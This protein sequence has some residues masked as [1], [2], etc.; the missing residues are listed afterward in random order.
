MTCIGTFSKTCVY[1]ADR[2]FLITHRLF[3]EDS[4]PSTVFDSLDGYRDRFLQESRDQHPM[5]HDL[6]C[7]EID[8][9][10]VP[11]SV[12]SD[13]LDDYRW[14]DRLKSG[15]YQFKGRS[16]PG[17][18]TRAV[19]RH[20][21]YQRA[22]WLHRGIVQIAALGIKG[23]SEQSVKVLDA[24]GLLGHQRLSFYGWGTGRH[25]EMPIREKGTGDVE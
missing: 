13:N 18:N 20:R 10:V 2:C 22:G 9:L 11:S 17:S 23:V 4:V 5:E 3:G 1:D 21:K 7:L 15:V 25:S 8:E 14:S 24:E 12:I 6:Q 16:Q 19:R